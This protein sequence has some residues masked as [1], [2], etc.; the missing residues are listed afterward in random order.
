MFFPPSAGPPGGVIRRTSIGGGLL[1]TQLNRGVVLSTHTPTT[2]QVRRHVSC[3][4][5]PRRMRAP[6]PFGGVRPTG[7]GGGLVTIVAT[8]VDN[9]SPNGAGSGTR[10]KSWYGGAPAASVDFSKGGTAPAAAPATA[11]AGECGRGAQPSGGGTLRSIAEVELQIEGN[12][13]LRQSPRN[14][15][16]EDVQQEKQDVGERTTTAGTVA[17]F[18]TAS[19]PGASR[20][21][22]AGSIPLQKLRSPVFARVGPFAGPSTSFQPFCT[23]PR[24]PTPINIPG[25]LV[26][27]KARPPLIPTGILTSSVC[28]FDF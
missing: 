9:T 7:T 25:A 24:R 14:K 20:V 21:V 11:T 13:S 1:G 2:S 4:L 5:S 23:S 6:G 18:S 27:A 28:V 26:G 16:A 8:E 22:Q 3:S 12:S 17:S 10:R 19:R 15:V